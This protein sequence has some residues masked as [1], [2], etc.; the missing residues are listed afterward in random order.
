MRQCKAR[1]KFTC[2]LLG[3]ADPDVCHIVPFAFNSNRDNLHEA[4]ILASHY[5][6]LMGK[7]LTYTNLIAERLGC[8]DRSWNMISMN[9]QMHKWWANA[10]FA[11]KCLGIFPDGEDLWV[12]RLQFCWMKRQGMRNPSQEIDLTI[13]GFKKF[14]NGSMRYYGDANQHEGEAI[15]AAADASSNRPLCSG[16]I[17]EIRMGPSEKLEMSA[18][19]MAEKMKA[20]LDFQWACIQIS[21][22][23]GGAGSPEFLEDDDEDNDDATDARVR[24]WLETTPLAPSSRAEPSENREKSPEKGLR[25]DPESPSA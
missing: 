11:L 19:E 1:D 15:V 22:M 8:S 14:V 21:V 7:G 16:R 18:Q 20:M 9:K 13:D 2:I 12:V 10:H 25:T 23:S 5:T 24:A 3:T 17:F 6:L 4:G